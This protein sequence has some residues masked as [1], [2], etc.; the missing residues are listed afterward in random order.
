M[1]ISNPSRI[2]TEDFPE[3][4]DRSI[5]EKFS[6]FNGFMDEIVDLVNNKKIDFENVNR[7]KAQIDVN[8]DAAGN[9]LSNPQIKLDLKSKP[10]GIHIV[11]ID[12]INSP[13]TYPN[14]MPFLAFTFNDT[15]LTITQIKGLT[16]S[17]KYRLYLEIIG[18]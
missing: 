2:R 15:I 14:Y 17:A 7:Q 12:N 9:M 4:Y 6:S 16:A 1:K 10:Y 5:A 13:G 8:T 3:E 18:S 11:R